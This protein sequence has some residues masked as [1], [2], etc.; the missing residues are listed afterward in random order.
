MNFQNIPRS[1]KVVKRAFVPKL[2]AFLLCD[3]M[4]I[5]LRL[6]AYYMANCGDDSMAEVIRRGADLHT[7]SARGIFGHEPDEDERTVGKICNFLMVYGGGTPALIRTLDISFPEAKRILKAFHATWPGIESV[8]EMIYARILSR[9]LNLTMDQAFGLWADTYWKDRSALFT[10]AVDQGGYI[11]TLW[12][13]QLRPESGHKALNA[14]VQGC[15]ADLMKAA[16]VKTQRYLS[17]RSFT[18]HIVSS[19]HD[20][21]ILDVTDRETPILVENL[22]LLMDHPP[23][24]VVVPIGV[25]VEYS[26]T[27][28]ADKAPYFQEAQAA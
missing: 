6:L 10:K 2:D 9:G 25:D 1:D 18:S 23:V 26:R 13:R 7:E 15:A 11:T 4:Q 27:S 22:P 19:V 20:E 28:W 3:Y 14:L 5:E 8:Q 21:L 24:S 12:G 17:E 16:L